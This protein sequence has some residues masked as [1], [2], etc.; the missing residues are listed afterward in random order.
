[1]ADFFYRFGPNELGPLTVPELRN[2]VATGKLV[3]AGEIRKGRVGPW[4]P[5]EN[6]QGLFP[7]LELTPQ[8][9]P[10]EADESDEVDEPD[11]D[12]ELDERDHPG[13]PE[14]SADLEA[15]R[16][17]IDESEPRQVVESAR[18]PQLRTLAT[19][20][21]GLAWLTIVVGTLVIISL[22]VAGAWLPKGPITFGVAA[23]II[24]SVVLIL[25]LVVVLRSAGELIRVQIDIELNTRQTASAVFAL[26]NQRRPENGQ[27]SGAE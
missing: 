27:K 22:F 6:V 15:F 21:D 12:D 26:L 24:L 25:N 16:D 8:A 14:E 9:P 20:Y 2:L 18:Y 3:P 17:S 19:F 10:D 11:D 5:A 7:A 4:V 13:E 23:G 1:M